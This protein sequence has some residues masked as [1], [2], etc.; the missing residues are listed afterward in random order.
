M[1]FKILSIILSFSLGLSNQVHSEQESKGNI[2]FIMYNA[3]TYGDSDIETGTSFTEIVYAYD[4]F[5]KH[6]YKV[7]FLTPDGGSIHLGDYYK[8]KYPLQYRYFSDSGFM[9]RLKTTLKPSE[10]NPKTYKAVYYVGGRAAMHDVPDNEVIQNIA[11]AIYE[12]KNGVISAVYHGTAGIVNLKTNNGDFLINGKKVNGYPDAFERKEK[13]YYEEFPFS[14][15]KKVNQHG[16]HFTYSANGWDSYAIAENRLITGQ[17]P[18]AS[19]KVAVLVVAKL[20]KNQ[21]QSKNN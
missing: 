14:I 5:V 20:Q 6:N 9:I 19:A 13:P 10:V 7:D 21:N 18:T 3:K 12:K 2:L 8:A 1:K 17:A 15:E 4:V 16:G 11:M